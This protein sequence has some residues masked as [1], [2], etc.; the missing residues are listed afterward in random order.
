[1]LVAAVAAFCTYFCMYAFRKPF[2]AGTFEETELYGVGLK[3]LLV[4]SQLAGY[5]LSKFIGIKVVSE[6][7]AESRAASIILLIVAAEAALVGFAYMPLSLKPAMLFLNGLPLG[8]IF[9]LVVAYLEGRRHTEALTA[10]LCASFIISSG[11]VK[12]VGRWLVQGVGVSEFQMPMWTGLIFLPALLVSVWVLQRTPSPDAHDVSLRSERASMDRA[13]RRAF[14]S[15]YWPGL[16]L[17]LLVYVILT[18]IRTLRD[19]FGVEIWRDLGIDQTPSV[20][21]LSET[22]VA[23]CVVAVNALAIW[24]AHNLTAIRATMGLMAAAFMGVAGAALLQDAGRA[25]PFAFMVACG[26]GLYIPYVAFHTTV[27]ERLI[28]ASSRPGNLAFLMYVADAI[29]YLGYILALMLANLFGTTGNMLPLFQISLI[30]GAGLSLVCLGAA[31]WYF[32]RV[33]HEDNPSLDDR[34]AFETQGGR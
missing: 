6:M 18:T 10:A 9:G 11:V 17:L 20:F 5:M 31:L 28:A 1:M 16:F 14:L 32:H 4:I 27:F 8:M 30:V 19:D 13:S 26:V 21:A 34:P 24:I 22:V 23:F 12:S 25:T 15:T 29:G 2:T 33:L 3:P 7:R